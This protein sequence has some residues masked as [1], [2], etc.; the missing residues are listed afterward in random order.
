MFQELKDTIQMSLSKLVAVD[1]GIATT[2]DNRL[3]ATIEDLQCRLADNDEDK[4]MMSKEEGEGKEEE[5]VTL[6]A[7]NKIKIIDEFATSLAD[8]KAFAV[9]K[10]YSAFLESC[11]EMEEKVE[12]EF[13]KLRQ[14]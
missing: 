2:S 13:F 5:D 7:E 10:G 6:P 4:E 1:T 8:M 12:A 9:S 3:A 14:S 11:M